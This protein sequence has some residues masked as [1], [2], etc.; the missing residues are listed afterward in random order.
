[1]VSIFLALVAAFAIFVV[2]FAKC[3]LMLIDGSNLGSVAIAKFQRGKAAIEQNQMDFY[4]TGFIS[5]VQSYR[6]LEIKVWRFRRGACSEGK[7]WVS[8]YIP[9]TCRMI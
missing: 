4:N 3:L 5:L 1:M 6:Q 8:S 7:A 2:A 9:M